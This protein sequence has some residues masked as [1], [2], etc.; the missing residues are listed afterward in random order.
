MASSQPSP[1]LE[2][3]PAPASQPVYLRVKPMAEYINTPVV[4]LKYWARHRKD[5]PQPSRPS[6]RVTLY[7][8]A[9]VVAWLE[10]YRSLH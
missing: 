8:V 2:T 6:S 4:T 1:H 9:E 5:F 7:P 10:R 3:S